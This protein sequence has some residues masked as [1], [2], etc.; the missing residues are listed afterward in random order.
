MESAS[1]KV[2]NAILKKIENKTLKTGDKLPSERELAAELEVSRSSVREALSAMNMMGMVQIHPKGRTT[3]QA[4]NLSQFINALSGM[5]LNEEGIHDEIREFRIGIE[6]ESARL[7]AMKNN[8]RELRQIMGRMKN[9]TSKRRAEK[10]DVEFHQKL[11][12]ASKNQLLIQA[13]QAVMT[14]V[15]QSIQRNRAIL[16]KK[17]PNLEE[18][19]HEHEQITIAIENQ[20]GDLAAELIRKHL[21]IEEER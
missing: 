3:L 17:Y 4:F 5:L 1:S 2:L 12:E 16:E 20:Q 21:E 15:E 11:A 13:S 9:C 6:C 8:A 18:L 14:L 7:A 10:L 19:I